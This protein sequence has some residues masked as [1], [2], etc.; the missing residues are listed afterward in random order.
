MSAKALIG[1]V[2]VEGFCIEGADP[3]PVVLVVLVSR[4]AK[5]F[6]H[7]RILEGTAAVLGRA[8]VFTGENCWN[9]LVLAKRPQGLDGDFVT[10]IVSE[11]VDVEK[12]VSG[13]DKVTEP[14]FCGI[15]QFAAAIPVVILGNA[16]TVTVDHEHVEVGVLPSHGCLDHRVQAGE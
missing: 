3:V 7:F 11:I 9:R 14:V 2:E 13:H 16:V 15:Q 12:P 1:E 8:G 10:P 4:I 6:E 5:G